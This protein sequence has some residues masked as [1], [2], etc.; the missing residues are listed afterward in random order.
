MPSSSSFAHK[1][2][3]VC[4]GGNGV[5]MIDLFSGSTLQEILG[6]PTRVTCCCWNPK[7]Y[8]EK[9]VIRRKEYQIVVGDANGGCTVFDI[10]K[11]A[12]DAVLQSVPP[13]YILRILST[14][15]SLHSKCL[16]RPVCILPTANASSCRHVLFSESVEQPPNRIPCACWTEQ[17]SQTFLSP[18][19]LSLRGRRCH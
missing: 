4:C 15:P 19:P 10:R 17:R 3:A 6:A 7:C 11:P 18:F 9:H 14:P 2:V 12:G 1:M 8:L 13:M 5:S 16:F